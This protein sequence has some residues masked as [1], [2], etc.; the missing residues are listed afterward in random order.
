MKGF[1]KIFW[2]WI[3][4]VLFLGCQSKTKVIPRDEMVKIL[5]DVHLLDGG[6]QHAQYTDD[7]HLPD[8]IDLYD[9]VLDK[10]GYSQEQF[11]SSMSHYS[12]N[13]RKF[14]RIYQEVLSRLNRMETEVKEEQD[15]RREKERNERERPVKT[16]N[17][18]EVKPKEI[19]RKFNRKPSELSRGVG[20][21]SD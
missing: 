12:R 19:P 17:S 20:G 1:R 21:S 15:K 13:P 8:S 5:V 2:V 9:Y 16:K 14:D 10:H 6:I 3:V 4:L 11:D 18:E 7:V